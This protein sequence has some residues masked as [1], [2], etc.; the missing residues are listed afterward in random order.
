MSFGSSPQNKLP[1]NMFSFDRNNQWLQLGH[2]VRGYGTAGRIHQTC[3]LL[4]QTNENNEV[5]GTFSKMLNKVNLSLPI[6]IFIRTAWGN[7]VADGEF[8]ILFAV[9][10]FL[11]VGKI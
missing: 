4:G 8:L 6:G 5:P 1:N 11:R 2:I 9:F 10:A 3:S 7:L